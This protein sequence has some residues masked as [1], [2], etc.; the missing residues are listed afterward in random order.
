MIRDCHIGGDIYASDKVIGYINGHSMYSN[1]FKLENCEVTARL[2]VRNDRYYPDD[3][4]ND[5]I[6]NQSDK[7]NNA[8]ATSSVSTDA[9]QSKKVMVGGKLTLVKANGQTV[10][11]SGMMR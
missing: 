7:V 10:D 9:N 3:K 5:T 1:P 6:N 11:I 4:H 2:F 8:A